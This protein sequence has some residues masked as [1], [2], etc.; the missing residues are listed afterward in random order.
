ML[1]QR[2]QDLVEKRGESRAS[3][4]REGKAMAGTKESAN[5]TG[6]VDGAIIADPT[7]PGDVTSSTVPPGVC[8][9]PH[10]P[11]GGDHDI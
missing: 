8:I 2:R 1:F 5:S 3:F 6:R 11:S 10:T 9:I 4:Q 7:T